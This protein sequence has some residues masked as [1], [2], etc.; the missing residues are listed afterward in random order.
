MLR[1]RLIR[2][3]TTQSEAWITN[4]TC[5]GASDRSLMR[6]GLQGASSAG[7]RRS[8]E[9]DSGGN[10]TWQGKH[11]GR[12]QFWTRMPDSVS[13]HNGAVQGRWTGHMTS[14]QRSRTPNGPQDLLSVTGGRGPIRKSW[15]TPRDR[16][17]CTPETAFVCARSVTVSGGPLT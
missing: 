17:V 9:N 12:P 13:V 8:Q 3:R 14:C 4:V 5:D 10:W 15:G 6:S 16:T 1:P 7:D 2:A 11:Q